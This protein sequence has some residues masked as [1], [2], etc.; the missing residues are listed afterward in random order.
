MAETGNVAVDLMS[1][2][3][4]AVE[5]LDLLLQI[6][7]GLQGLDVRLRLRFLC[8]T[9][10]SSSPFCSPQSKQR[11]SAP[12]YSGGL[13]H[14]LVAPSSSRACPRAFYIL[15]MSLR[16]RR[17]RRRR[18]GRAVISRGRRRVGPGHVFSVAPARVR[19][20]RRAR[21]WREGSEHGACAQRWWSRVRREKH[22]SR[23]ARG[24]TS[25]QIKTSFKPV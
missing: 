13:S 14:T 21:R 9:G 4:S 6:Q 15:S 11:P 20:A 10:G 7:D 5:G 25:L 8:N 16:R 18:G 12:L 23:K 22:R 19:G 24:S 1:L 2:S 3:L 17:R